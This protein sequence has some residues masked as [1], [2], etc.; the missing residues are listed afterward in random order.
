[1]AKRT[2]KVYAKD[3]EQYERFKSWASTNSYFFDVDYNAFVTKEFV[4]AYNDQMYDMDV[5]NI[6]MLE[7][8]HDEENAMIKL[9]NESYFTSIN[10]Q[11][12][13]LI[14][15]L[16]NDNKDEK[17]KTIVED[18]EDSDEFVKSDIHEVSDIWGES[19]REDE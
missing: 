18:I 1:M 7:F 19:F 3:V 17:T 2:Y 14:E 12:E 10:S 8:M 9:K 4:K 13:N 11:L 15:Q 6:P 5:E 16:Q